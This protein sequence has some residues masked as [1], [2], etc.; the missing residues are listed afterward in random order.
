GGGFAGRPVRR[1]RGPV[2]A[3]A[4]PGWRPAAVPL[5]GAGRAATA[6]SAVFLLTHV[7]IVITG[8]PFLP[9]HG[10][11]R[12]VLCAAVMVVLVMTARAT[13]LAAERGCE[14]VP[15]PP[16]LRGAA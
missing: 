11:V 15:V 7:P 1:W 10:G 14:P 2:R 9:F 13:R 3:R 6:I 4:A 16:R 12:R 8:S 5:A